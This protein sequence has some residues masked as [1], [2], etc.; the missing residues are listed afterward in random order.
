MNHG[1]I[2]A[3]GYTENVCMYMYAYICAHYVCVSVCVQCV[4]IYSHVYIYAVG[5]QMADGLGPKDYGR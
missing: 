1:L 5:E 4:Y 3:Y 2:T